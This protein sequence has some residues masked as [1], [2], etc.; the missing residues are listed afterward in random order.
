MAAAIGLFFVTTRVD[1]YATAVAL[2]V[3][4][5]LAVCLIQSFRYLRRYGSDR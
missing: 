5:G 2:V 1:L 3:L 4:G